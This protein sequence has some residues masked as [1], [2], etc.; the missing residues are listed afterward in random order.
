MN[1]KLV[2]FTP[3]ADPT[4]PGVLTNCAATVPSLRGLKGAPSPASTPLPALAATCTGA[5]VLAK[6]DNTTRF[7]AGT[8]TKLYEA[9][10]TSWADVSGTVY[11]SS[12]LARWRFTQF[13]D[14]SLASNANDTI[15][16]S[17]GSGNFA[18]VSGAPKAAVVETVGQ[19]VFALNTN[20]AT[21][22]TSPDRWWCAGIGNYTSWTPSI[23]TQAASGRLTASPG[24]ITAARRFGDSIVVYKGRSMYL[25]VYVG[26][27]IIWSFSQIPGDIGAFS[28]ETVVNIGTP[29]NPKHIF[30]GPD[31][32]FLFDGAKPVPIGTNRV[33]VQVYNVLLQSRFYACAAL[34]DRINSLVY[35]YYPVADSSLPDHCVVY[36]YRT[37]TWG[38][39]DRQ[40]E[41][42]VEYVTPGITYTTLGDYYATYDSLPNNTYD[43]AFLS[44]AL[45]VPAVFDTAHTPK[46]LTG[47]SASSSIT[48]G[49][50]GDDERFTTLQRVRP[51][52]ITK[53]TSASMVNYYRNN[54]GDSLTTDM[55]TSLSSSGAF[56]VL[57]DARWHRARMDF[58]GDW[59]MAIFDA[60]AEASGR[61]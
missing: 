13:G 5:A 34:H 38:Q 54:L 28:Q 15:Q 12:S 19:F 2:G 1:F 29:E 31:N 60:E 10:A 8:A 55:S 32:F 36:N 49:D 42:P 43:Q 7:F 50:I 53:P 48:T 46:T 23:A 16:A 59:E 22:G 18:A 4:L 17:N 21:F 57:R 25:G 58:V 6:L 56:D 26:P 44:S 30:M 27:P 24:P 61:E 51:R 45:S 41:I 39:D 33:R 3:D 20:E 14:V 11:G 9:A 47:A 37:D 52:F 35:F 40:I